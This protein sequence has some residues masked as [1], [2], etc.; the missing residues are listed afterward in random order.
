VGSRHVRRVER[1]VLAQSCHQVGVGQKRAAEGDRIASFV[2]QGLF[3]AGV[4][5]AA[6][7]HEQAVES[8]TQV[9]LEVGWHG[10][11]AHGRVIVQV[12]TEQ[13]HVGEQSDQRQGL[14]TALGKLAGAV[15][16]GN[17]G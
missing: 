8:D 16:P 11:R 17:R 13:A 6:V 7:Q 15:E 9:E 5:E 10:R 1:G 3:S 14:R 12:H 4:V 2:V